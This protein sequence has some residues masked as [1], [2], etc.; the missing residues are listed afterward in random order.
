[1][2]R[3]LSLHPF[4]RHFA[5][6]GASLY[7]QFFTPQLLR[8]SNRTF[9]SVSEQKVFPR[10][11]PK[12]L[13]FKD[14]RISNGSIQVFSDVSNGYVDAPAVWLRDHCRCSQCFHEI[15]KQRVIET[16]DDIPTDVKVAPNGV[17]ETQ[18]AFKVTWADGHK[19]TYSKQW[20]ATS[21]LKKDS[22]SAER[23]ALT[24]I[25]FWSGQEIKANPPTV[26][27]D[28][29]MH[30]EEGLKAWLLNI[31]KYGFSY[32]DNCPVTPEASEK[33]LQRI[34]F[35]RTTHYGGFYDFTA[36]LSSGDTAYTQLGIGAHTDNTYFSDPAGL[37]MFHLLSHTHGTGGASQLVDGFGAAA[38]L[39][40]SDPQ[41]YKTLSTVRVHSHASGGDISVQP[42]A[43]QPVLVH[44]PQAGFLTQVRWNTTDRAAIDTPF[45]EI[46]RWYDAARKWADILRRRE[47]W[48]QLKPGKPLI[49]DNWRVLHGRSAFTGNRRMCGGYI[50]RDDY[51]SRFK[52]LNW[53]KETCLEQ[54]SRG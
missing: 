38:D 31:R 8:T 47:Y 28:S 54:V 25:V 37:Q 18:D 43:A 36:D 27:Y 40:R 35:I 2:I 52:L 6:P 7:R 17:E 9:A 4:L 13:E 14:P 21:G 48:E 26:S 23:Q 39:L 15:T 19:S 10:L 46:G 12:Q 1:M 30:T 44:D 49:F 3:G 22:R 50:N 51:I 29:I 34:A 20:L 16:F 11:E 33:L 32:V 42:W 45:E 41:A 53:G 5:K 24:D